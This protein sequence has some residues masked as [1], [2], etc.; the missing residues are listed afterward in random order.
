MGF[1]YPPHNVIRDLRKPPPEQIIWRE[2]D[3]EREAFEDQ[4]KVERM[5]YALEF[6]PSQKS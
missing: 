2:W 4:M 3:T 6:L 5:R 1:H